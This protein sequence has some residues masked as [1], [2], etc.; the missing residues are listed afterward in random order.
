M[1]LPHRR[2]KQKITKSRNCESVKM[3]NMTISPLNDIEMIASPE[4]LTVKKIMAREAERKRKEVAGVLG[5]INN[6]IRKALI[7]GGVDPDLPP[8]QVLSFF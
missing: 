1:A 8:P 4:D 5:I 2:I 7:D 6:R 3:N